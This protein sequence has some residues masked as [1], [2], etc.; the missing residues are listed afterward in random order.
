MLLSISPP[1]NDYKSNRADEVGLFDYPSHR[2]LPQGTMVSQITVLAVIALAG[3]AVGNVCICPMNYSPVCGSNGQTFSNL[4]AL[5]CH[6]K[7][8]NDDLVVVH[9]GHCSSALQLKLNK[10]EEK[11]DDCVCTR[12]YEPVCGS[13]L[14]TYSNRCMFNCA[15]NK[16]KS[17]RI[18]YPMMCIIMP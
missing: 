4:C 11:S 12:E 16:D 7:E 2:H 5:N 1:D 8:K 15:A 3:V 10:V 18:L 9:H 14:K 17:L 6:N 13:N